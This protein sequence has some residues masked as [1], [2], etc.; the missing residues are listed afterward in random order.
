VV[1]VVAFCALVV[2]GD[3][4]EFVAPP[5]SLVL[6]DVAAAELVEV[7]PGV[8]DAAFEPPLPASEV[9]ASGVPAEPPPQAP[10]GTGSTLISKVYKPRLRM[11]FRGVLRSI[12]IGTP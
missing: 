6:P 2:V 8:F 9:A 7:E 4:V 12:R 11:I 3:V 10:S 1:L 5:A